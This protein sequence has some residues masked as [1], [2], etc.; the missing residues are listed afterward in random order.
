MNKKLNSVI[1]VL[2]GTLFNLICILAIFFALWFLFLLAY[3]GM[4]QVSQ[5]MSL[6]AVAVS[7]IGGVVGGFFIYT[8]TVKWVSAKWG[9]EKYLDPLIGRRR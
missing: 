3:R 4:D 2:L 5:G 6:L 9:L 8:K 7:V 1:F